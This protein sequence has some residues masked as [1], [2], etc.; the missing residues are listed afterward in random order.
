MS[1]K[2]TSSA[3]ELLSQYGIENPTDVPIED[4]IW[5]QGG[6][7]QEKLM[8]GAE[9]RIIFGGNNSAIVT[10]N[11]SIKSLE[12]LR[13][14]RA[15]E[16]GHLRLHRSLRPF[17][18]CD[19]KAFRERNK[20]GSHESEANAFAAE[21][22]MPTHLFLPLVQFQPFNIELLQRTARRFQTSLTATAFRYMELGPEPIAVFHSC[23]GQIEWANRS[24]EF[25]ANY[26]QA[27][28]PLNT[29]SLTH[30]CLA[31]GTTPIEP[32]LV[33]ADVWF[34]DRRIPNELLFYEACVP[35]PSIKGALSFVWMSNQ[36]KS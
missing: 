4:L 18:H 21:L 34:N 3:F 28:K 26:L 29:R 33:L 17:F 8:T 5:A 36:Y 7:Y 30:R 1:D 11:K 13:F 24:K 2:P 9:G 15:H 35:I 20:Q 19:A 22:L 32:E 14:I 27:N 16:L 6:I 23:K 31:A 10:I 12:K 25:L